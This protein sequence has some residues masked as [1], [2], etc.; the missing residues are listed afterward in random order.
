ML[1]PQMNCGLVV[2]VGL[3]RLGVAD[4]D[5]NRWERI[6]ARWAGMIAGSAEIPSTKLISSLIGSV[7]R[8]GRFLFSQADS[9][10]AWAI[11]HNR[12]KSQAFLIPV[13]VFFHADDLK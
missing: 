5:F 1:R 7:F 8:R 4:I 9:L 13:L 3:I 12:I 2:E 11:R 6:A 10:P